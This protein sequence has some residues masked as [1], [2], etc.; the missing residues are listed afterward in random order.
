MRFIERARNSSRQSLRIA[1][2]AGMVTATAM[3]AVPAGPAGAAA[4]TK[5]WGAAASGLWSS[6]VNWSPAGVPSASDDVCITPNGTYTV[7]LAGSV[8]VNSIK[9]GGA[10]GTAT[11]SILGGGSVAMALER[12]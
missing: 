4:C 12:V 1:V 5:T 2:I 3:L 10:S 11:L 9:V 7:T 8:S 6:A